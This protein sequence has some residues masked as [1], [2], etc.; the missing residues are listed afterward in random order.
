MKLLPSWLRE[1]VDV[2]AD[3]QALARDLTR[4]GINIEGISC[5]REHTVFEAEITTNRP[6]AMNHYG[7]AREAAA[8]YDAEL[9]ALSAEA[10]PSSAAAGPGRV[11]IEIQ[12]AE[13]CARYT[14]RIIRGIR[15][16]PSPEHIR[17]RLELLGS[18]SISNIVDASN[19]TL[20][21]MGH[22]THAFDLDR[23]AGGR[24]LVRRARKG[25][26]LKTLDGVERKLE[27]EDVVIAD[28]EKPVALAGIM[29]GF[30]SMITPET[31]NVLV[32]SAWFDPAPVRR[33]ARRLGMHT[34]ASHRFE[35]GADWGGTALACARVAKLIVETG[36]GELDGD[37]IDVVARQVGGA[38]VK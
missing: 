3:D 6:D 37:E 35:R 14:A 34:D 7:V 26:T 8:I 11:R 13:G 38:T 31:R 18:S 15:I 1:F 12:D 23:L 25:E 16:G 29:G 24:I 27:P 4:A 22:P 9:K 21:E 10:P 32:E 33:T 36:G 17:R 19:Y 28:A 30:N 2:P 5:E 20:Q